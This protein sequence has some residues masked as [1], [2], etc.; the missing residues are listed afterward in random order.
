MRPS[1]GRTLNGRR[2]FSGCA[3]GSTAKAA[4]TIGCTPGSAAHD[5]PF[6]RK[7]QAASGVQGVLCS[8]SRGSAAL[9]GSGS[10]DP[11]EAAASAEAQALWQQLAMCVVVKVV[12]RALEAPPQEA[13]QQLIRFTPHDLFLAWRPCSYCRLCRPGKL[14]QV[15]FACANLSDPTVIRL[16]EKLQRTR[17]VTPRLVQIYSIADHEARNACLLQKRLDK[18][19]RV[20]MRC[21]MGQES[22]C[23]GCMQQGGTRSRR[24]RLLCNLDKFLPS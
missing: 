6:F 10:G 16:C 12:R 20:Q 21:S 18:Q 23:S 4:A 19:M 24:N 5:V 13:F 11:A 22:I 9:G 2:T 17:H 3:A 14:V 7:D 1:L 15:A 8:N